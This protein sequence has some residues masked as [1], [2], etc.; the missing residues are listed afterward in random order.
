MVFLSRWLIG[1]AALIGLLLPGAT[2]AHQDVL[3]PI[4]PSGELSRVPREFAPVTLRIK[5]TPADPNVSLTFRSRVVSLPPCVGK[6]FF[7]PSGEAVLAK[8]SWYHD[9]SSLPPYV[10][11]DLPQRTIGPFFTGHSAIF[12]LETGELLQ[13]QEHT[14]SADGKSVVFSP[15]PTAEPCD[16]NNRLTLKPPGPASGTVTQLE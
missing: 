15:I 4:G 14:A 16:P 7:P 8:G 12:N 5:G 10:S 2:T 6:L 3:F 9:T 1:V 11:F 13:L